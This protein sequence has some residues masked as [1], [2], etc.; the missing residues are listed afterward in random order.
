MFRV[1]HSRASSGVLFEA[2]MD[3]LLGIV[4]VMLA[5][6]TLASES[7]D[8]LIGTISN[9]TIVLTALGFALCMSM[10]QSFVGLYR[11]AGLS[12]ASQVLRLGVAVALGSYITYLVLKE[13]GAGGH[14]GRLVGLS[15]L[16]LVIALVLVRGAIAGAR[17]I[18]GRT[19]VMIVGTGPEALRVAADL[20][21][22]HKLRGEVVGFY[23][24]ADVAGTGGIATA[25][26][27]DSATPLDQAARRLRVDQIIVTTREQR[28]GVMPMEQLV[29]CRSMGIPVMDLAGYYERT[30]A[31]VPLESLKASFL[32]YGNGFVQGRLRQALKRVF[33]VL[34]SSVLLVLASPVMLL[35]ALAIKLDSPGP[36]IYRQER[37]GLRGRTF[38][39]LKFRSMRTDAERDGVARWASKNDS[40]V[41]RVGRFIRKTRIDELPQ[42]FS[43]LRGEMSIVGPRPE[44]PSFVQE[45]RKQVSFYDLR[46]TVKPGVTGWAQVR[47]SYGSSVE[48]ARRKHQFD[49]YYV[50]NNSLVLDLVILL[51]T[52]TVVL[53]GEGQ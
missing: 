6:A 8:A 32:V 17:R 34:V 37:V 22:G 51:E 49:L 4:A 3:T 36:I 18:G 39:C 1:F 13:V 38:Q 48:D 9:P 25:L 50:K 10:L 52:V 14:P 35:A 31:E 40:R 47:Y 2:A 46:H 26:L 7:G 45:L 11:K 21:V 41:T 53:F 5:A 30:N 42:L 29:A 15:V 44:R 16:N 28:G 12:L 24:T 23:P 19:R 20:R 27:I 43:V 33:D